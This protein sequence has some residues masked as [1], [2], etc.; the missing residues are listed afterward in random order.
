MVIG[1]VPETD[2]T[3]RINVELLTLVISVFVNLRTVF[4]RNYHESAHS[5][6]E[7]SAL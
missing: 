6:M 3:E 4:W 1:R 7:S 5:E 2:G